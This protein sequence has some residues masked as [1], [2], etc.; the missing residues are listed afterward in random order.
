MAHVSVG[1][2]IK[3]GRVVPTETGAWPQ[4]FASPPLGPVN[5]FPLLSTHRLLVRARSDVLTADDTE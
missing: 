4:L 1:K 2:L 5:P 3:G